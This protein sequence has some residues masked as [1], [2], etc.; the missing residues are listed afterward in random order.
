MSR[1][2]PRGSRS[3]RG[4]GGRQP[5]VRRADDLDAH[6]RR[7]ARAG[8]RALGRGWRRR[9]HERPARNPRAPRSA[10]R[11]PQRGRARGAR[12]GRRD[13]PG[14][15]RRRSRGA[16]AAVLSRAACSRSST[17]SCARSSSGPAGRTSATGGVR[18]SPSPDP[19]RRVR[20]ALEAVACRPP[21]AVRRLA[22]ANGADRLP[23]YAEIVGWHLEQAHRNLSE[24]GPARRARDRDRAARRRP[25][26][27]CGLDRI[28]ARR[29][30]RGR[31]APVALARPD[32]RRRPASADA[33]RR[34]RRRAP[35]E[36]SLRG[37]G[38]ALAEAIELADGRR[39][40]ADA[41]ARA[42]LADAAPVPGRPG[43]RLRGAR[44]GRARRARR[45]ARR[46]ATT[47]APPA[48]GGS[49]TGLAGALQARGP[50]SR[51]RARLRVRPPCAGPALPAGRPDRRAR[52]TRLRADSRLGGARGRARRS[53]SA[54]GA[55]AG[56]R[57]TRCASSV[58]PAG[59]S[60][61]GR[62]HGR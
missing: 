57:P 38:A 31:H 59:C 58:R 18:V 14:L 46:A 40:R 51:G 15:L 33:A 3:R 21:R 41:R 39:R 12:T 36:R 27:R 25:S 49:C 61:S 23:E 50:P 6:R 9:D 7:T 55:T 20:L 34:S 2:R 17:S 11:A 5:A 16:G 43:R 44:G 45:S 54:F 62:Q 35:L 47:S 1:S 53:S 19:R 24:L 10:P 56:R 42:A 4:A 26:R 52:I 48:R 30:L 32:G 22:R 37:G 29:R 8:R 28:G 13:G 60:A